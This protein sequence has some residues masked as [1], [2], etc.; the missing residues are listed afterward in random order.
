VNNRLKPNR[1][2]RKN[3]NNP[4]NLKLE[5]Y[6]QHQAL[7][8]S[9]RWILGHAVTLTFDLL[10]PKTGMLILVTKYT[11]AGEIQPSKILH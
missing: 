3:E 7:Y 9:A 2:S 6:A 5:L 11:N 10:T 4:K 1:H 8:A